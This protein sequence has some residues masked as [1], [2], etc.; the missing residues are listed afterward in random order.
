MKLIT[1]VTAAVLSLTASTA[2]A[3]S[4]IKVMHSTAFETA[5][6]AMAGGGF[7]HIMNSGDTDDT[8]IDVRADYPRV[9]LH[10]TEFDD[11]VAKMMHVEGIPVPAGGMA[12]LE[13]GG[14]HVMFMGLQGTPFALGDMIPATLVF[15]HAGEVDIMFEVI[16]RDVE[17]GTMDHDDMD[18]SDMDHGD[19]DH[20][21]MN[22]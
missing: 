16:A 7:M 21:E 19:V 17:N 11:G 20:S 13:P 18:H 2:F 8:L 6:T 9:E 12:T 15:E 5:P 1:V 22:H 4:E 14:Y 3:D 10:T